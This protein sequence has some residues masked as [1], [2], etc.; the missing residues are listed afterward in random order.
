M[1]LPSEEER[2]TWIKDFC[3]LYHFEERRPGAEAPER[4]GKIFKAP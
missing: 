3:R 2:I 1:I 4:L